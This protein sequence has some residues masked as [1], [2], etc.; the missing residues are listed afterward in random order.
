MKRVALAPEAKGRRARRAPT[1]SPPKKKSKRQYR[2]RSKAP[3]RG[4]SENPDNKKYAK[5]KQ[6]ST[7]EREERCR[8]REK[9]RNK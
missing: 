9:L 4:R 7:R 5:G 2:G 1:L 3:S 8:R 6:T